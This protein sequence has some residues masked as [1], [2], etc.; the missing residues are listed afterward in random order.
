MKRSLLLLLLLSPAPAA[1]QSPTDGAWNSPRALELISRAQSRRAAT[2]GDT[3][4]LDYRAD[5]RGYVY[6]YLD[7]PGAAERTLV[8]TD[9][10]ALDVLWKA[11]GMAKQRI[12]GLRDE[13]ELPTRIHYHLDHLSVVQDNFGDRIRLGDG[14]EVRDVLHPAAPGAKAFY[15]YRLADS[16]SIRLP[17]AGDAVQVHA[18][19]VRPR[20]LSQPAFIGSIYIEQRRGDLVR[21]DFT[22]TPASYV[23]RYLDYINV[24]LDNGLWKERFWLPNQQRVE[25]RRQLPELDFPAGAVIRGTMRISNYR[26]NTG[27]SDAL[28]QGAPVS[29]V[30]RDE[31]ES[32]PFEEGLHAELR[33]EGIGPE[34]EL[35]DIR[36]EAIELARTRLLSGLPALRL[37]ARAV[38]GVIR[39]NRAEGAVL[40]GGF[41]FRPGGGLTTRLRGG[42]AFGAEH[43]LAEIRGELRAGAADLTAS[44]Y[45]NHPREI[46]SGPLASGVINTLSS[47]VAGTDHSDLYYTSGARFGVE[48]ALPWGW[49]LSGSLRGEDHRS[50]SLSTDLSLW[51]EFRPVRSIAEGRA[52]ALDLSLS[53]V[54]RS[55]AARSWSLSVHTEGGVLDVSPRNGARAASPNGSIR[56]TRHWG[57]AEW[58]RRWVPAAASLEVGGEGG[59]ATGDVPYQR[60]FFMGGRGTVPGY[61]VREYAGK[62]SLVARTIAS[63]DLLRPWLRGRLLTAAGWSGGRIHA[64]VPPGSGDPRAIVAVGIGAGLFYDILRV[65]LMR[66]LTA[67][68]R[69]EVV[70]ETRPSFWGFL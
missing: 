17:G 54:P 63:A 4:L 43:P 6:F 39:Y 15:E 18:V 47:L 22:F 5:A 36:R 23:D 57:E 9:Q 53:R 12:V 19:E 14:D 31:R 58:I 40:A 42:Y 41:A 35:S 27:L 48:R 55:E 7:R 60:L 50:A 34:M 68:G 49:V 2:A 52:A 25:I 30:P 26:F 46:G 3:A 51:G 10:V 29:A 33:E 64:D 24:S 1:A 66:G 62:H 11:P 67:D 20:D 69:W 13:K 56:W 37:D 59:F 21:M 45:L 32:F 70:V 61:A 16:L 38:S 28:F 65:D 44:A 8:K